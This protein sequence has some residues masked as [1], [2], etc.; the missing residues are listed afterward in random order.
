MLFAAVML[1]I[2]SSHLDHLEQV[3]AEAYARTEVQTRKV[4]T[5]HRILTRKEQ[6]YDGHPWQYQRRALSA[7]LKL[8][9]AI[10]CR[11]PFPTI[12]LGDFF[13]L[14]SCPPNSLHFFFFEMVRIFRNLFFFVLL[15]YRC[16]ILIPECECNISKFYHHILPYIRLYNHNFSHTV[17][18]NC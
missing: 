18:S 4:S 13:F 12:N 3:H 2:T 6:D 1:F 14:C 11:P 5:V 16:F 17:P 9:G 10:G 7:H 15:Y 8:V